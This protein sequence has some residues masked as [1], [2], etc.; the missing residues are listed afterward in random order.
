MNP[1]V[2]A[3]LALLTICAWGAY[4]QATLS[5]SPAYVYLTTNEPH[6]SFRL[7]NEGTQPLEIIVTAEYGVIESDAVG[8]G[9]R[10]VLGAAGRLGDLADKLSFFPQRL[11]LSPGH[12]QVVR[13]LVDGADALPPGGHIALMHFRMQER[14]AIDSLNVP[15]VA[16]AISIEYSLVAPLVMVRGASTARLSAEVLAST[17]S[18]LTL[19]MYNESRYPFAGHIA[20]VRDGRVL[21]RVPAAVYT[22]RRV[23][24]PVHAP[25]GSYR[26]HFDVEYP[27]VSLR[28][29]RQ[30][31]APPSV[32]LEL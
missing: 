3:S 32:L 21:G 9:A 18:T 2:P 7:R 31:Q 27:G 15:A 26:L 16:T 19:L 8:S 14:A 24:I 20:L 10:V 30:L 17:D 13:Y 6:G 11:I 4:G 28:T 25:P 1:K 23:V 12:E 5:V 29:R 22:R